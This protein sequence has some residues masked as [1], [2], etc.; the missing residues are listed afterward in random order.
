MHLFNLLLAAILLLSSGCV[1]ERKAMFNE[2]EFR[3]YA[4][5]GNAVIFGDA[6][7]KTKGGDI[8]RA[9][10]NPVRCTDRD[11]QI[12]YTGPYNEESW[13]GYQVQ[14]DNWTGAF[15][16]KGMCRKVPA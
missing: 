2:D 4:E 16:P 1:A 5:K 9:A 8:K 6:F 13:N 12:I 15:Y 3:P 10:G 7:L 11:G 14:L